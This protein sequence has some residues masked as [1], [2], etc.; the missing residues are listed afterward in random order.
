MRTN[1]VEAYAPLANTWYSK[2]LMPTARW[3]AAVGVIHEA[4]YVVGG[5]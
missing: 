2:A 4:L 1:K 3:E 5:L